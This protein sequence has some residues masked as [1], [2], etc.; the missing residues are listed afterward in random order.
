MTWSFTDTLTTDKDKV[1]ALSGDVLTTDQ[2]VS[3]EFITGYLSMFGN[4]FRT[5]AAVCR[6]LAAK[7]SRQVSQARDDLRKDLSDRAT[8][9]AARAKELD[10]QA[11]SAVGGALAPA[12]FVGGVYVADRVMNEDDDSLIQPFFRRDSMEYPHGDLVDVSEDEST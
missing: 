8:A 12:L 10:E 3:D 9:Y 1:R 5:A 6:H 4:V 11:S 7:Y 2:Q